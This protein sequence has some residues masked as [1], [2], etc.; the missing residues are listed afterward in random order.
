M[1]A[2]G[3]GGMAQIAHALRFAKHLFPRHFAQMVFQRHRVCDKFHTIIKTAVSLDVQVFGASVS[4]VEQLLSVIV[5]RAAVINLQLNAEVPQALA[6][7]HEIGGVVVFMDNVVMLVPAG[8][9]VDVVIV[10]PIGTVAA[11]N[12]AAVL[13]ADVILIK[14]VIAE[15]MVIVL[16]GIFLIDSIVTV[17]ADYGQTVS[18]AFTKPVTFYLVHGIERVLDTTIRTNSSFF[19]W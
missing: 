7:K 1:Q 17:V 9:A 12:A 2:A 10:I 4:D 11:D 16:N 6:V 5:Y 19:H 18:T 8:G 14:T 3:A 13:T 15:R